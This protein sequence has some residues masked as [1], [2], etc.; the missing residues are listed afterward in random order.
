MRRRSK[1]FS[2]TDP[3]L[4]AGTFRPGDVVVPSAAVEYRALRTGPIRQQV[5]DG[6]DHRNPPGKHTYI[7]SILVSGGASKMLQH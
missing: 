4:H 7:A 3:F 2:G 5:T 6:T 1:W